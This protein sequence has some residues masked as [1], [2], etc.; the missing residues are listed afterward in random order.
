MTFGELMIDNTQAFQL[1]PI[2]R[3]GT[4]PKQ[5]AGG[6]SGGYSSFDRILSSSM[7]ITERQAAYH[8][9]SEVKNAVA[10]KTGNCGLNSGN[11]TE[12]SVS[13]TVWVDKAVKNLREV[14]ARNLPASI[15]QIFAQLLGLGTGDLQKLLDEAGVTPEEIVRFKSIG[16]ATSK[17][18]QLP[19]LSGSQRRTLDTVM[20]LAVELLEEQM[21]TGVTTGD[22]SA[23]PRSRKAEDDPAEISEIPL[24]NVPWD[25]QPE[26]AVK[27]ATIIEQPAVLLLAKLDE[28]ASRL[29]DGSDGVKDEMRELLLPLI[30]KMTVKIQSPERH[31]MKPGI[32]V[33][34]GQP[35]VAGAESEPVK[36]EAATGNNGDETEAN[37]G[38]KRQTVEVKRYAA[39][40]KELQPRQAFSP[41]TQADSVDMHSVASLKS[42]D[43]PPHASEI[44]SQVIENA[45]TIIGPD[46]SEMVMELKPET[47]GRISLKVVTEQGIVAAKFIADNQRVRQVL[48]VNMQLLKDSL[49]KQGIQVQSF[50]VSVRQDLNHFSGNSP[51]H[52]KSGARNIGS[53]QGTEQESRPGY[54]RISGVG[55]PYLWESSTINLMA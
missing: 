13:E 30:E 17:M 33:S 26:P 34:E 27:T 37:G 48:E 43:S 36:E 6:N 38:T 4:T 12:G 18:T 52:V 47:L 10:M 42:T 23:V 5:K 53:V 15:M 51:R 35:F 21:A 16:A 49:E 31:E 39:D 50:S 11:V 8:S 24:H 22:V 2:F 20:R 40:V 1:N 45:K 9:C 41:V 19:G 55:N 3:A 32:I 44:I 28:Y 46:K 29:I 54:R 14:D 7:N 25:E